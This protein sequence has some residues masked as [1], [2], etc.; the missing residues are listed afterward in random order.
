[1]IPISIKAFASYS[2]RT[3]C[4]YSVKDFKKLWISLDLIISVG[5][6]NYIISERLLI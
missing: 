1:M 5:I 3:S 2:R 6:L 4:C